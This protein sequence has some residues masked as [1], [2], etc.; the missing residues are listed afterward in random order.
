ME[1]HHMSTQHQEPTET[2]KTGAA[3]QPA[4]EGQG[5]ADQVGQKQ[6]PPIPDPFGIATDAV[7]G[8]RLFESKQDH[9]MAIKFGDGSPED[10]PSQEV[11]D[12]MKEAGF[13]WKPA[14][15]IWA[16]PVRAESAV[17]ARIDA[18]HLFQE[19]SQMIRE[20]KGIGAGRE[21]PF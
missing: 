18:E 5:F 10:K 7:A 16:L 3:E 21:A 19:V 14:D 20:E 11:I 4:A 17:G 12:K 9:Q 8:V 2:T 15:R 1:D 6:R 13:K